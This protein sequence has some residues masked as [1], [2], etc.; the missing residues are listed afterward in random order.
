M[1]YEHKRTMRNLVARTALYCEHPVCWMQPGQ[2][3][4]TTQS[5]LRMRSSAFSR[6]ALKSGHACSAA[7]GQPVRLA[8]CHDAKLRNHLC[9]ASLRSMLHAVGACFQQE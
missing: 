1:Y 4:S 5:Q 2:P 7:V 8:A 3:L 9:S 6:S